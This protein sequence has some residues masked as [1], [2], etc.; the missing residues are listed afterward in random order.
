[1]NQTTKIMTFMKHFPYASLHLQHQSVEI[2]NI[3]ALNW[4]NNSK[5]WDMLR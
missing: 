2:L 3:I 5:N 1:M 4:P